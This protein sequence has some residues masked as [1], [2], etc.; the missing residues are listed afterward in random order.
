M[1]PIE[2]TVWLALN[3]RS[4]PMAAASPC[5]DCIPEF[6]ADM[7]D[8][9]T[10]DGTITIADAGVTRKWSD[11]QWA[12]KRRGEM[13]AAAAKR[14]A[15]GGKHPGRKHKYVGELCRD[16]ECKRPAQRRYGGDGKIYCRK[17]YSRHWN[18]AKREAGVA[19]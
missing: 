15:A 8:A 4:G 10:C 5:E 3:D 12:E 6:R 11:E 7:R 16:A 2:R 9:G 14:N 13:A 19:V 1:T 18:A 17:H